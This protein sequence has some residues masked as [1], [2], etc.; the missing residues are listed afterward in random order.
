MRLMFS[1]FFNFLHDMADAGQR[2]ASHKKVNHTRQDSQRQKKQI[3]YQANSNICLKRYI[4]S[5]TY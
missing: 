3:V 4:K 2:P 5:I 1:V